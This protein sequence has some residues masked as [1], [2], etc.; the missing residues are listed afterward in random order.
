MYEYFAR[1]EFAWPNVHLFWVDERGVP[2]TD[3]QSNFRFANETWLEPAKYP[4]AN[5]HRVQ[6]ELEAKEAAL[7][8]ADDLARFFGPATP[9][10]DVMH[11]GMGPDAHTASLFPGEPMLQNRDGVTAA[12]WVE[13][14][15][16]FRI[17]VLPGVIA[18]ARNRVVLVAGEDKIPA[19]K[20]VLGGPRDPLKAPAQIIP[21]DYTEWFLDEAAAKGL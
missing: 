1:T 8:Y 5:I 9:Q 18:A 13:K 12:V 10:F 15:Q 11:M 17:T 20:A 14:F 7:L 6:A 16:Q 3:E 21:S 4:E 19:L 2:P